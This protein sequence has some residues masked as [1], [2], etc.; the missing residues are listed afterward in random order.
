MMKGFIFDLKNDGQNKI[1]AVIK[2]GTE[3]IVFDSFDPYFYLEETSIAK[4]IESMPEIKRVE[5]TERIEDGKLRKFLKVTVRDPSSVIKLRT[6]LEEYGP[7]EADIPY[8]FRYLI[9]RDIYPMKYYEFDLKGDKIKKEKDAPQ[10]EMKLKTAAF[11][12]ETYNKEG[13]PD[14]ERDPIIIMSYANA[15]GCESFYWTKNRSSEKEMLLNFLNRIKRD[16]PDVLIGY[17]S[18]GFDVPYIKKRCAK[19]DIEFDLSKDESGVNVK[20]SAFSTRAD[21]YGRFHMD[22]Y[23]GVS[24]LTSI[25]AM[26]IPKID[27]ESAYKELLGKTKLDVDAVMMW[28]MWENGGKE[29]ETLVQYNKEDSI[30]AYE[31]GREILPLYIELSRIVGLPIYEISRMST[32]QMVEWL[33]IRDAFKKNIIVPPHPTE[34]EAQARMMN[35]IKGAFVK[36]PKSGLHERI[37]VCDFRSLYP[38]LIMEYNIDKTTLTKDK[39]AHESPM[40]HRFSKKQEG[41]IPHM[42]KELVEYRM[43]VKKEMKKHKRDSKEYKILHA[44][45]WALKIIANSAYG[46]MGYGRAKWYSREAAESVTAWARQYIHETIDKAE[47][48]G[49]DVLYADTDSVFLKLEDKSVDDAKAFVASVNKTLPERMELEF[50]GYYTR[51]I[52]V[53]KRTGGAAKKK[54]ALMREDKTLQIKGFELVRRDWANVA[55]IAQEQVIKA[56]LEEGKPEK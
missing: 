24:F 13:M 34:D 40:G 21:T 1:K 43:T 51:G 17:N 48:A 25:G 22:A 10:E 14:A 20:R 52:F 11:D 30:A 5:K 28:K 36:L 56:V 26:S 4:E 38:S 7:R 2:N 49:F 39:D 18:A 47:K 15:D 55:K 23:D 53:T 27:L 50:D 19:L 37:V 31:I 54:Y 3:K 12:I 33:L 6:D 41:L 42:L 32:S 8:A 44:R 35:P 29:L 9:D 16:N 45:Q 46:Y